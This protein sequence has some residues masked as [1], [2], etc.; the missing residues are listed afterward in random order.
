M[1]CI[2]YIYTYIYYIIYIYIYIIS[3]LFLLDTYAS[4]P[5]VPSNFPS[6]PHP[7]RKMSLTSHLGWNVMESNEISSSRFRWYKKE[8]Y[9]HE[10]YIDFPTGI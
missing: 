6:T 3:K 5:R 1:Y 7:T 4:A 10:T 8:L 2:L 9:L